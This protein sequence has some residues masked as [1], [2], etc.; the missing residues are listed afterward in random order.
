MR[1]YLNGRETTR[2]EWLQGSPGFQPGRPPAVMTDSVFLEGHA[3]GNQFENTPSLGDF[4]AREAKA[5]GV[6]TKGKV[7]LS[8]LASHPGDPRA[9]VSG[10]GDVRKVC[11]ER[12]W[13]C[14][15]AVNVKGD[16]PGRKPSKADHGEAMDRS[17]GKAR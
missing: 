4:Y 5:Q 2:E 16:G 9:W 17:V 10:R 14:E 13:H 1:Y 3:N 12:G 6:D 7:Y 8:G 11:E 15:G